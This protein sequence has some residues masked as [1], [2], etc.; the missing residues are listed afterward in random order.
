MYAIRSYYGKPP[1]TIN[2][3]IHMEIKGKTLKK[4]FRI[5][6][7]ALHEGEKVWIMSARNTLDIR[8]VNVAWDE[9]DMVYISNNLSDGENLV[10]SSI[11]AP[12]QGM[13]LRT[14]S[15][16]TKERN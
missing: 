1:L 5:P 16:E 13:S 11:A 4:A 6:R 10:V 15:K 14:L 3:F 7:F 9:D 12:V 8:P 2:S